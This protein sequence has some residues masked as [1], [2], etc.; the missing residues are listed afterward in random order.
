MITLQFYRKSLQ[1]N[2]TLAPKFKFRQE[3]EELLKVNL[4]RLLQQDRLPFLYMTK[5]YASSVLLGYRSCF[6]NLRINYN[7]LDVL[8]DSFTVY[9]FPICD[10]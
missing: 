3:K 8:N 1:R 2:P 5:V 9:S 10:T 6:S 4:S 7:L